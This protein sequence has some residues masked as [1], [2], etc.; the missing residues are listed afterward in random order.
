MS[1]ADR[2]FLE[3]KIE[4]EIKTLPV[5]ILVKGIGARRQPSSEYVLLDAYIDGKATDGKNVTAHIRREFHIVD[6][7]GPL[8]LI[9]MDI[10]G[11]E[12]RLQQYQKG[13]DLH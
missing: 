6:N 5:P 2:T 4:V 9:G 10:I 8:M 12:D 13:V 11:P 1:L 3:T 7:L